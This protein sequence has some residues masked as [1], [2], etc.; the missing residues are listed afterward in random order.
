MGDERNRELD[1]ARAAELHK[2][3]P[4]MAGWELA[5][6][7]AEWMR[8]VAPGHPLCDATRA[9]LGCPW[10]RTEPLSA[11]GIPPDESPQA[12]SERLVLGIRALSREV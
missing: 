10:P 6:I 11:H 2:L 1:A 5:Q 3:M 7:L 12:F 9:A 4:P 8:R